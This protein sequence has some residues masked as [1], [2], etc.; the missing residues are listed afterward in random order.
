M[1]FA[2]SRCKL[3][4][5]AEMNNADE[6]K[7]LMDLST[8]EQMKERLR[9]S[10]KNTALKEALDLNTSW[11]NDQKMK[12]LIAARYLNSV[13]KGENELALSVALEENYYKENSDPTKEEFVVPQ[14]IIDALQWLLQ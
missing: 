2:N 3:I 11:D 7:D 1:A 14:Y 12:G 10:K 8:L 9:E 5:V 4:V 13:S 6:L